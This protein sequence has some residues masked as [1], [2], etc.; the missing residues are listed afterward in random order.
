MS[1]MSTD[2]D[3]NTATLKMVLAWI[4]MAVGGITLSDI[5]L[6]TTILFT[7]LQIFVLLRKLWRGQA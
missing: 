3:T 5:A 4:G 1:R 6:T 7:V 2:H